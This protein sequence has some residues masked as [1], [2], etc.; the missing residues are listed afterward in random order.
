M[1]MG[2]AHGMGTIIINVLYI[3]ILIVIINAS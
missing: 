1:A 3:C 2:H